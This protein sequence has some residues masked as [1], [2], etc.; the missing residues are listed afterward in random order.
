MRSAVPVHDAPPP[1][2]AMHGRRA[3]GDEPATQESATATM[4]Q[5]RMHATDDAG[6]RLRVALAA[7]DEVG[8]PLGAV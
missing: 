7:G 3:S 6:P 8:G 2:P 1:L 5:G 4:R